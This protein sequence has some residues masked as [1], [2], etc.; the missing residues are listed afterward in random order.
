MS[1]SSFL[2]LL[3]FSVLPLTIVI[4]STGLITTVVTLSTG[5]IIIHLSGLFEKD[6]IHLY[7]PL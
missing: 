4:V 7:K 1:S 2:Q 3:S 6:L 5:I